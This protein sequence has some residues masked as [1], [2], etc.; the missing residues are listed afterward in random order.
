MYNKRQCRQGLTMRECVGRQVA[1]VEVEDTKRRKE[2][3][4]ETRFL[5]AQRGE[6]NQRAAVVLKKEEGDEDYR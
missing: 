2:A 3:E 5:P 6:V 1:F 4:D